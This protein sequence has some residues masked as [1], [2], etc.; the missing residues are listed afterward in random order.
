MELSTR[1]GVTIIGFDPRAELDQ[2]LDMAELDRRLA[3]PE[4]Q[5][6]DDLADAVGGTEPA[7][8]LLAR[9]A[10][11][12]AEPE[13]EPDGMPAG[14]GTGIHGIPLAGDEE[15]DPFACEDCGYQRSDLRERCVCETILS[16]Q[17][18]ADR[19]VQGEAQVCCAWNLGLQEVLNSNGF[20]QRQLLAWLE[21][22]RP[23]CERCCG[24]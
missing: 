23:E 12:V 24:C 4:R 20:A 15:D 6:L 10:E 17:E 3:E 1:D 18:F 21:D 13:P 5:A 19:L 7:I 16:V 14:T 2:V 22:G 11:I 9:L 8:G